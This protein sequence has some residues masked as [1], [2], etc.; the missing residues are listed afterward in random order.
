M[1]GYHETARA[2]DFTWGVEDRAASVRI[3]IDV[4]VARKVVCSK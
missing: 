1:T 4:A 2:D 3:P